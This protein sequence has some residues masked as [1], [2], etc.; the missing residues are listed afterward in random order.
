SIFGTGIAGIGRRMGAAT[1]LGSSG[2]IRAVGATAESQRA[3][4]SEGSVLA[5]AEARFAAACSSEGCFELASVL[6]RRRV[7]KID[8]I[9]RM[10]SIMEKTVWGSAVGR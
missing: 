3:D 1:S 9:S 2:Q 10:L 7:D 5:E 8:I 6:M 4:Y